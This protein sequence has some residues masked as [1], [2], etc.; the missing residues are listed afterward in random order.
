M[1]DS[2]PSSGESRDQRIR[3]R[4]YYLWEADGRPHGNEG[5]YWERAAALIRAEEEAGQSPEAEASLAEE[6]ASHP[7]P[8]DVPVQGKRRQPAP[9]KRAQKRS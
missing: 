3:E 1:S 8:G 2:N 7:Q 5:E 9:R 4:A 6:A